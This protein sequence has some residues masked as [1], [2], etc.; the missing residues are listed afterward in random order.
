MLLVV[1][2]ATWA[3]GDF[4]PFRLNAFYIPRLYVFAHLG[5]WSSS[6]HPGPAASGAPALALDGVSPASLAAAAA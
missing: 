3:I 6:P 2:N 1:A 4:D 5:L